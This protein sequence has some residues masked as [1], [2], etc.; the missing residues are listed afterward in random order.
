MRFNI[1]I[2]IATSLACESVRRDHKRLCE[3]SQ[4]LVAWHRQAGKG[5]IALTYFVRKPEARAVAS[6]TQP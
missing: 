1:A 6:E 5:Q 2:R 3:A 4:L